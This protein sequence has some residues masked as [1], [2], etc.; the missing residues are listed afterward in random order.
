MKNKTTQDEGNNQPH[1]LPFHQ[2]FNIEV[3]LETAKQR[4]I[5]RLFNLI[6]EGFLGFTRE[7]CHLSEYVE[8]FKY[9]AF[10]LGIRYDGNNTLEYY[11]GNEFLQVLRT[12]EALF[13]A[14]QFQRNYANSADRLD[15]IIKFAVSQSEIDLGI[16]WRGGLFY[17]SG[18]RLMDEE[19]VNEPLRWLADPK[20]N[21]VLAPFKKGLTHYLEANKNPEKLADTITDIYEALEAMAKVITGRNNKDLSGNRELFVSK[22]RLGRQYGKMLIDYIDYANDYRHG[23]EPSKIRANPSPNEVEAFI[24][25]TGLFI[26]LAVKQLEG[27]G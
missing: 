10:K 12:I 13:E 25:T 14:F 20:Y 17:P 11:A 4:F 3:E 16:Q 19:L 9:V 24:Y 27:G 7:Q 22:L 23:T 18:A 1:V 15:K 21:N 2:R 6:D 5:S 8:A 26:R